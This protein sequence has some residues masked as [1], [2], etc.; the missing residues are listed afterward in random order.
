MNSSTTQKQVEYLFDV[1]LC[2][3]DGLEQQW[4]GLK[5]KPLEE[6]GWFHLYDPINFKLH[7]YNKDALESVHVT[8]KEKPSGS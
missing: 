7:M 2:F 1:L 8:R 3:K 6:N 5:Q 4:N